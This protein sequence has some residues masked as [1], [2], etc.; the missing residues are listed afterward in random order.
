M[1]SLKMVGHVVEQTSQYWEENIRSIKPTHVIH[2]DDWKQ[3]TMNSIRENVIQTLKE[4]GGTL[5]EVPYTQGI[6]TTDIINRCV[7]E[8]T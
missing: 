5:V 6:S 4:I 2:G 8:L 3:G 1:T 7:K